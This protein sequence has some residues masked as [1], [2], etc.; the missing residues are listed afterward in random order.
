MR[1]EFA[2]VSGTPSTTD[3]RFHPVPQRIRR[4][5]SNVRQQPRSRGRRSSPHGSNGDRSC[6]RSAPPDRGSSRPG[7]PAHAMRVVRCRIVL[8]LPPGRSLCTAEFDTPA[9]LDVAIMNQRDVNSVRWQSISRHLPYIIQI[10]HDY[11]I[12]IERASRARMIVSV[13]ECVE[14]QR[15]GRIVRLFVSMPA[16]CHDPIDARQAAFARKTSPALGIRLL[17]P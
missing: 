8:S 4:T 10:A 12:A 2:R 11:Y 9:S 6:R 17:A 15:Q 3:T 5:P 16:D 13:V 14:T 1:V 7:S